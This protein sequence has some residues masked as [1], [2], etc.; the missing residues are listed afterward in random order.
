MNNSLF[1]IK[2]ENYSQTKITRNIYFKNPFRCFKI[3]L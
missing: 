3:Y 1:L 2:K